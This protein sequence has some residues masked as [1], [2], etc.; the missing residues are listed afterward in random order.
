MAL[1]E[2]VTKRKIDYRDIGK[3]VRD[4]D[5]DGLK[6]VIMR[7][8]QGD[9]FHLAGFIGIHRFL[10]DDKCPTAS[11]G[12]DQVMHLNPKFVLEHADTP[13][14][15][16][17]LVMHEVYH[18]ILRHIEL[19]HGWAENVAMDA[20]INSM[21][22]MV[23]KGGKYWSFFKD[24]YSPVLFPTFILRPHSN[25]PKMKFIDKRYYRVLYFKKSLGTVGLSGSGQAGTTPRKGTWGLTWEDVL[26][27]IKKLSKDRMEI[28][29]ADVK[30]RQ[31]G[32]QGIPVPGGGVLIGDHTPGKITQ[33]EISNI[34]VLGKILEESREKMRSNFAGFGDTLFDDLLEE[35]EGKKNAKLAEAFNRALL[36]SATSKMVTGIRGQFPELP[37]RT[38]VPVGMGRREMLMIAMGYMPIFWRTYSPDMN[39]GSVHVYIDVSGSMGSWIKWCY[40]L[41]YALSDWLFEPLHLFS[42]KIADITLKQLK[43]GVVTTTGGTDFDCIVEHAI[44]SNYK[45]II[46]ITDGYANLSPENISMMKQRDFHIFTAFIPDD[47]GVSTEGTNHSI[48]CEVSDRSWHLTEDDKVL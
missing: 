43:S 19:P 34:D 37:E 42:N 47:T 22:C 26:D 16:L 25:Y 39:R 7:L 13:H 17:M 11:I 14:K 23:F 40:E 20:V 24:Y 18:K 3:L 31:G 2:V 35:L 29:M 44:K 33:D 21:L 8:L 10:L 6:L 45:R 38:V 48:L 5:A 32:G 46:I 15:L 12:K 41:C 36:Q 30:T 28:A 4:N 1:S 27:W 9:F